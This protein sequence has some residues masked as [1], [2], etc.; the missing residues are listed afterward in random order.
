LSISAQD[1]IDDLGLDPVA[2]QHRARRMA[3]T[4]RVVVRETGGVEHRLAAVTR[5]FPV[6]L[7][8]VLRGL[9]DEGL[10]GVFRQIGLAVDA[11]ELLHGTTCQTVLSVARPIGDARNMAGHAAVAVGLGDLALDESGAFA[12]AL[13]DRAVAQHQMG[14]V[15]V[16]F[17]GRHIGAAHHETHV[18]QGAGI[19]HRLEAGAVHRVQ[20]ARWGLVDQVEESREGIA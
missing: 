18:A 3:D 4:R 5:R 19:D 16:P 8:R 15:D 2:R 17:M 1:G 9:L 20:F 12:L 13:L 10:G 7:R 14:E 11:R 6:D